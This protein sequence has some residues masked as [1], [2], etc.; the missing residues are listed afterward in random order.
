MFLFSSRISQNFS[1]QK[2][3][4]AEKHKTKHVVMKKRKKFTP[5]QKLC[6]SQAKKNMSV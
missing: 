1:K 6:K 5:P 3:I 4:I 2:I